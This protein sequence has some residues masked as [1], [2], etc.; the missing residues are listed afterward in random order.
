M[1]TGWFRPTSSHQRCKVREHLGDGLQ[2]S[3]CRIEPV[4][5]LIHCNL[6]CSPWD[7]GRSHLTALSFGTAPQHKQ[8]TSSV[9]AVLNLAAGFGAT[10]MVCASSGFITIC[11]LWQSDHAMRTAVHKWQGS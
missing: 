11:D 2:D 5:T 1:L 8:A 6:P 9:R 10:N 3:N 7:A 4:L